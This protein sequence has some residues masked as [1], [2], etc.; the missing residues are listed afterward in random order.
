[1][2][3][4]RAPA[5]NVPHRM[6]A[7][8]NPTRRMPQSEWTHEALVAFLAA[9]EPAVYSRCTAAVGPWLT[10]DGQGAAVDGGAYT[11]THAHARLRTLHTHAYARTHAA[12]RC[13]CVCVAGVRCAAQG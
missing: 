7:N 13:R 8:A 5:R 12:S 11:H 6:H 9:T 10:F 3:A 2:A 1:M 4:R